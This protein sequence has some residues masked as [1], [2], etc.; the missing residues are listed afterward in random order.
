MA[1]DFG[2]W[3]GLGRTCG[4]DGAPGGL[5]PKSLAG[6]GFRWPDAGVQ[7]G[8]GK[9]LIRDRTCGNSSCPGGSRRMVWPAWEITRAGTRSSSCRS[10]A[11]R[12][13]PLVSLIPV[14]V[15]SI[16][17]MAPASS[18]PHIHTVLTPACPEGE[19]VQP[20]AELG[21]AE[22]FLNVGAPPEPRL[23]RDHVRGRGGGQV[24]DD[25]GDRVGVVQL[26]AQGQRELVGGDGPPPPGARVARDVCGV[27]L[28]PPHDGVRVRWPP[29]R[30]VVHHR[31]LR[32]WHGNSAPTRASPG[33]RT[34]RWAAPSPAFPN[35][36]EPD[37]Q[38]IAATLGFT[39]SQIGLAWLL[40]HSSKTLL[41][42]GTASVDHLEANL[43][44]SVVHLDATMIDQLD[45]IPT[46]TPEQHS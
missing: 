20:G 3:S 25:E 31:D 38:A 32:A 33:C 8:S 23:D 18:A 1:S 21:L 5:V 44:I 7:A 45:R 17:E 13:V 10:R 26:P 14:R 15:C 34:S 36:S 28:D 27:D 22:A 16:T 11:I 39:P 2:S 41:I 30:G 40:Q 29:G 35:T 9:A 24:G 12:A 4:P 42:P 43:A 19:V 6:R 37:V 46:R